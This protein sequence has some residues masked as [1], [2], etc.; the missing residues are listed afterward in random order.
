[1]T[2]LKALTLLLLPTAL[3]GFLSRAPARG[4]ARGRGSAR[5]RARSPLNM[6]ALDEF[7]RR[8][9]DGMQRTF[10][11]LTARLADDDVIADPTLL[12]TVS[13]QRA[14]AEEAVSAYLEYTSVDAQLADARELFNSAGDDAEMREM[15]RD[16]VKELE[17]RATG[18]EAALQVLLLPKDPNDE[19]NV[20]VEV[21]AG[22]AGGGRG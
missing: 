14:Q 15:A 3:V 8:Q 22:I 9:L 17:A 18:L 12:R 4:R 6:M 7:M 10:D 19:R 13:S 1:M 20:M 11:E 5:G 2:P 16:E 21:R